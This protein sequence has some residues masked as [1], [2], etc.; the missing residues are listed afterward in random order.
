MAPPF[1][2]RLV[3][4]V[5]PGTSYF[6]ENALRGVFNAASGKLRFSIGLHFQWSAPIEKWRYIPVPRP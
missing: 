4:S 5:L 3:H 1:A 6:V 2:Q